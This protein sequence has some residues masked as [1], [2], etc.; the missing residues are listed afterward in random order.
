MAESGFKQR[1]LKRGLIIGVSLIGA[2]VG[3]IAWTY[4]YPNTILELVELSSPK[5]EGRG[6]G[7]QG[8][9]LARD[10]LIERLRQSQ[11][12]PAFVSSDGHPSYR[13][14]F[15][16]FIGNELGGGNSFE[17]TSQPD[18]YPYAF[19]RSGQVNAPVVFAGFGISVRGDSDFVYDDYEGLDVEGK[20]VVVL[21]GDPG[22]GNSQ[23]RFRNPAYYHYSSP[24]YKAINAERHGAK[25]IVFVRD[26]I[27]VDYPGQEEP[28]LKFSPRQGGGVVNPILAGQL[29]L[30][31]AED[32]LQ[33]NL[34]HW[35]KE[36]ARTQR[37]KSI[38]V[39]KNAELKVSLVRRLGDASNIGAIIEGSDPELKKEVVV[40]GAHYDH[41][42]YG[43]DSSL[44]NQ[45][46][47]I[48]PGA[49]DNASGVQAVLNLARRIKN[50][51]RTVLIL[52][53]SAEEVGLL[54]SKAFT[55]S[56]PLTEGSKIVAMLN[57]DMVGRMRGQ[58]L[59]VLALRS[60][61]EFPKIISQV[62]EKF[63]LHLILGDSGFGSS[64]HASFLSLKIPSIFFTTG[65]HED[66]HRASDTA[67]KINAEG[68]SMVEDFVK[69]V[70]YTLDDSSKAPT[71]D[72]SIEEGETPPREGRGYGVYFGSIP[73]FEDSANQGVLLKGVKVNSPAEKAGLRG[74]DLLVGLGEIEIRN[75]QDFVF[76]LRFYR[77]KEEVEVRW[78]RG[79][80]LHKAKA[81]LEARN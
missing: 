30:K 52:F 31:Y 64:D 71:Y 3:A 70:F 9:N 26:P 34:L 76:A 22:T 10:F 58:D 62:N 35:Q 4:Q 55:E 24:I 73:E 65:A 40:I 18:F 54:G 15:R 38:S 80:S 43:G 74:G 63:G 20:I 60:G 29:K 75:L 51:Q 39:S 12:P 48:H 46:N 7:T 16:L 81:L 21:H 69:D 67:E 36:V 57:L 33:I 47:V 32:F 8:L 42:G 1:G 27:S 41:L 59:S 6:V 14:D 66:Y 44:D 23:S 79:S 61:K 72:S 50:N 2:F 28:D 25:A 77:P 17:D 37:P 53:F 11:R 56:M 45:E 19:S 68:L 5:Y 78:L 49:D 13:Q